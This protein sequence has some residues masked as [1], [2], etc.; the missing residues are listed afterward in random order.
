VLAG[1]F[2]ADAAKAGI[3]DEGDQTLTLRFGP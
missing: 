2:A 1:G 3:G